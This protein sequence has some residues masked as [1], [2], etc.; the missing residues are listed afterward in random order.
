MPPHSISR[1]PARPPDRRHKGTVPADGGGRDRRQRSGA[2]RRQAVEEFILED[3][4]SE[5]F[6]GLRHVDNL[7]RLHAITELMVG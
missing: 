3:G 6:A 4:D 5:E 7:M 2:E 1:T